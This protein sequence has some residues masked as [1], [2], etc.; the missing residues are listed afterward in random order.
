MPKSYR[1]LWPQLISFENLH[2]AWRQ[3]RRGKRGMASV[4]SFEIAAED[5]GNSR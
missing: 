5:Q 4:A 2:W 1:Q 3:A